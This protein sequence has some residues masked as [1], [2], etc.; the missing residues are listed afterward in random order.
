M[1]EYQDV[2]PLC[3]QSFFRVIIIC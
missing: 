2:S 1:V 3:R